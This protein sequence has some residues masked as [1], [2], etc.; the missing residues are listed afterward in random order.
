[1]HLPELPS[2]PIAIAVLL[3]VAE[4]YA[5]KRAEQRTRKEEDAR[6]ERTVKEIRALQAAVS[7]SQPT[8]D[9][10]K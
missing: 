10:N 7:A 4:R 6:H 9:P 3:W 5:R 1:M 2:V 8:H